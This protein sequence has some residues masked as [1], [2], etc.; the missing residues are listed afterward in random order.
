MDFATTIEAR[1]TMAMQDMMQCF[2]LAIALNLLKSGQQVGGVFYVYDLRGYRRTL[3][4]FVSDYPL[5]RLQA[6]VQRMQ[7]GH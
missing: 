7:A 1:F 3:E 5:E 4:S 6:M 2:N